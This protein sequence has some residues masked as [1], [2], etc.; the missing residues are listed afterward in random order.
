MGEG[1]AAD[2]L[3][4]GKIR[5]LFGVRGWLRVESYTEPL[6][7]LLEYTPWQLRHG[8]RRGEFLPNQ[9]RQH[10]PGL[11]VQLATLD[12]GLI[13]DRSDAAAWVGA[14]IEVP[15][16]A[17]PELSDDQVYWADLVG[18][19]VISHS[20][21]VLGEV[22]AVIDNPAHPLLE[23]R[24]PSGQQLIPF[25]RGPIVQS[26]DLAAGVLRVEWAAEYAD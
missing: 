10:G 18:L 14:T 21:Q 1:G 22:T 4:L 20:D 8:E 6:G 11:V 26:V 3:A 13:S 9:A 15:R 23:L 19:T 16:S 12:G 5:G 24:G 17:L 7:N 25:V 2:L